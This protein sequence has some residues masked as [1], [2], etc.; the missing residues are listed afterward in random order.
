MA[1]MAAVSEAV[2]TDAAVRRNL[3][4]L[5]AVE[6]VG[7]G[8]LGGETTGRV[9]GGL[10]TLRLD[11]RERVVVEQKRND[12][13]NT[14]WLCWKCH[15]VFFGEFMA[16]ISPLLSSAKRFKTAKDFPENTLKT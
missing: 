6:N 15:Q 12:L 2:H 9:G 14:L 1:F 16:Q 3:A 4:R 11:V 13:V 7:F 5:T 10:C 8:E